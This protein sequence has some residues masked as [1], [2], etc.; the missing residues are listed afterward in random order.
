[1]CKGGCGR[2]VSTRQGFVHIVT[3]GVEMLTV[4]GIAQE[5]SGGILSSGTPGQQYYDTERCR[6]RRRIERLHPGPSRLSPCISVND[7]HLPPPSFQHRHLRDQRRPDTAFGRTFSTALYLFSCRI[8]TGSSWR[9]L[10]YVQIDIHG[11]LA[12]FVR[13]LFP[14]RIRLS[15][16][17]IDSSTPAR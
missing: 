13:L 1:M 12:Q 3:C 4:D 5:A 10:S 15:F 11:H 16:H 6:R 14:S 8:S 2:P 7:Q 17:N 9:I